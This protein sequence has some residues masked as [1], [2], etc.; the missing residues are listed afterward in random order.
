VLIEC[1]RAVD[2]RGRFDTFWESADFHAAGVRF[3]PQSGHHAHTERAAT[4]RGMHYQRAP[5]AQARLVACASGRVWDVVLDLRRDSPT[6]LQWE[7]TEL[8]PLAGHALFVPRGCAHGYVTLED[9]STVTYL[10]EGA[11]EPRAAAVVRW[12]DPAVRIAWPV[13]EPILSDRDRTAPDFVP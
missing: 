6:Y 9:R 4:L 5:H 1:D 10:I 13:S 3:S 2:R 7:G 11:Y 12:N 8:E